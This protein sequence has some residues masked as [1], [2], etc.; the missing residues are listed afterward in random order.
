MDY[1]MMQTQTV[2]AAAAT[3]ATASITNNNNIGAF[4]QT[5]KVYTYL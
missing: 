4:F 5:C 3:S 1:K 2:G